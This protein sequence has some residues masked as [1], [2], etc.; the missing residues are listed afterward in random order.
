MVQL[1][2]EQNV[3]L[4][5]CWNTCLKYLS[6]ILKISMTSSIQISIVIR[7]SLSNSH[8]KAWFPFHAPW[9][10]GSNKAAYRL[11]ALW[12]METG[13]HLKSKHLQIFVSLKVSIVTGFWASTAAFPS[14]WRSIPVI[15]ASLHPRI[16]KSHIF[17]CLIFS[18]C[19]FDSLRCRRDAR[20]ICMLSW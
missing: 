7:L 11:F 18:F 5:S 2:T 13:A 20:L 4:L 10:S 15:S 8:S 1:A 17:P 16:V 3:F 19:S 6:L 9:V 12:K 14:K